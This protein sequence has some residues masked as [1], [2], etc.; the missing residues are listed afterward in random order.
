MIFA[1]GFRDRLFLLKH[2][3]EGLLVVIDELR[4][5]KASRFALENVVGELEHI[6]RDPYVGDIIEIFLGLPDL[7][8]I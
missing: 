3:E 2:G 7:V 5:I 8:R 6:R 1:I 4:R